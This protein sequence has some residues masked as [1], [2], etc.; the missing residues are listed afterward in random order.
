MARAQREEH[1]PQEDRE[2]QRE[3]ARTRERASARES[4][5]VDDANETDECNFLGPDSK[6]L[7][8]VMGVEVQPDPGLT[9]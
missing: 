2:R 8:G 9:D 6:K 1:Q 5:R 4:A 7:K 3:R